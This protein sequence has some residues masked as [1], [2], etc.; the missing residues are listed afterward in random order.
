MLIKKIIIINPKKSIYDR[1]ISKILKE[2]DRFIATTKTGPIINEGDKVIELSDFQE[3][4]DVRDN[5]RVPINYCIIVNH[6]KCL[7]YLNKGNLIYKYYVKAVDLENNKN[8]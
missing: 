7:F 4:L 3:L 2:Y 1:Y 8:K 5:L 6:Q